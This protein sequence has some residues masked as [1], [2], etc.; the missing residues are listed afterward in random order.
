MLYPCF[1]SL[2]CGFS[3]LVFETVWFYQAGLFLGR[4]VWTISIVVSAYMLGCLAGTAWAWRRGRRIKNPYAAL[5]VAQLFSGISGILLVL[6]FPRLSHVLTPVFIPFLDQPVLLNTVRLACALLFMAI[7]CFCVGVT[8]PLLSGACRERA[9]YSSALGVLYGA[10]TLGAVIGVLGAELFLIR[11]LGVIGTGWCAAAYAVLAALLAHAMKKDWRARAAGESPAPAPVSRVA[12]VLTFSAGFALL[13]L[14]VAWFRFFTLFFHAVSLNFA[15]ILSVL[16]AGTFCG[17]A[18]AAILIRRF[19]RL[20]ESAGL[21]AWLCAIFLSLSYRLLPLLFRLPVFSVITNTASLVILSFVFVFPVACS[22]GIYFILLS[23]RVHAGVKDEMASSGALITANTLGALCGSLACGLLL[24]P[25]LGVEKTI[26]VCACM[27][28]A[29]GAQ[30]LA[31]R[32]HYAAGCVAL[33]AVILFPFGSMTRH[34]LAIPLAPFWEPGMKR[35]SVREGQGET[36][37]LVRQELL[38]RP[39]YYYLFSNSYSMSSTTALNRRYMYYFSFLPLMVKPD[40]R[41]ALVISY[42]AGNTAD[43]LVDGQGIERIDVVD[44]SRDMYEVS[45]LIYDFKGGRD[46][47]R[48]PRVKAYIE[49]GRFFLETRDASYDLITAEPPPP[50]TEGIVHLYTKEFFGLVRER[51]APGGMVTYWLPVAQLRLDEIKAIVAAF[52]SEFPDCML[53]A[54]VP[55][56]W[57]MVGTKDLSGR[58]PSVDAARSLWT[59]GR[60]GKKLRHTGYLTPEDLA[61]LFIIDGEKLSS[62]LGN[63]APLRDDY[64]KVLSSTLTGGIDPEISGLMSAARSLEAFSASRT[65][66]AFF[67]REIRQAA[68]E[69]FGVRDYLYGALWGSEDEDSIGVIHACFLRPRLWESVLWALGSDYDAFSIID[70]A[71]KDNQVVVLE[72]AG[73][74]LAAAAVYERD[75]AKAQDYYARLCAVDTAHAFEFWY[76]L[77]LYLAYAAQDRQM[78][79]KIAGEYGALATDDGDWE[80]RIRNLENL[81]TWLKQIYP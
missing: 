8:L 47:L 52:S 27:Y 58:A 32:A 77:R 31:R 15:L 80:R 12:L 42:G 67:C 3:A 71:R 9:E 48:D 36:I 28:A 44:V 66:P 59:N 43:A 69:V 25:A 26:W 39:Y 57:V 49:D 7:P 24:I 33:A 19:P 23:K 73:V 1:I 10:N 41:R 79:A 30:V 46:P 63:Q 21:F 16:L 56:D 4:S 50:K 81:N 45:S 5:A 62:W 29:C 17:S 68:E 6:V 37:Q 34:M 74:H 70:E 40:M 72:D 13:A 2:F 65:V 60:L 75:F 14:E 78:I 11:S 20:H 51:L 64:P 61:G 54:P 22:S 53:F 38:G 18:L 76:A 55:T 35:V